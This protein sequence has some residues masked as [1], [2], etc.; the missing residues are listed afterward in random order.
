MKTEMKPSHWFWALV[1]C[2]SVAAIGCGKLQEDPLSDAP[3]EVRDGKPPQQEK[4]EP[5]KTAGKNDLQIDVPELVNATVGAPLEI[6]LAG[7][8]LIPEVSFALSISNLADFPNATVDAQ[9]LFTWTPDSQILAGKP[10]LRKELVVRLDTL[11][12]PIYSVSSEEKRIVVLIENKFGTPTV[13]SVGG[14]A[15]CKVGQSCS[16]EVQIRDEDAG[17]NPDN[18]R[19]MIQDCSAGKS[20]GYAV[21]F[22][23][24]FELTTTPNVFKARAMVRLVNASSSLLSTAKYCFGISAISQVHRTS[25]LYEKFIDIQGRIAETRFSLA[26][27]L[28]L[29]AGSRE[30]V[31]FSFYDPLK[32]G[33]V[34]VISSD[35]IEV[36]F[37]GSQVTCQNSVNFWSLDCIALLDLTAVTPGHYDFN[38]RIENRARYGSENVQTT[39]KMSLDVQVAP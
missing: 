36:K 1:M 25:T 9:G 27:S 12:N 23:T 21:D 3:G 32:S 30:T 34:T 22:A 8:V 15:V 37:P 24:G 10:F 38:F 18:V 5:P 14:V 17:G 35:P 31:A 20:I 39:H 11:P 33:N 7:R 6:Q 29:V 26:N 19:A 16:Y 13:V 28:S 2:V 4:A